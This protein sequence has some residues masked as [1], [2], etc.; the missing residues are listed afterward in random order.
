[1]TARAISRKTL[2][3]PDILKRR[4]PT[5]SERCTTSPLPPVGIRWMSGRGARLGRR[6]SAMGV[7]LRVGA[8]EEHVVDPSFHVGLPAGFVAAGRRAVQ[9]GNHFP[10]VGGE[11][12]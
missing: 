1:M 6:V 2:R 7:R 3:K 12:E 9:F 5:G 10:W 11:E 4:S 8:S